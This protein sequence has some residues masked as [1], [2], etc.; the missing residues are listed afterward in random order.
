MLK[1]SRQPRPMNVNV[2]LAEK[3]L[4]KYMG[5]KR[6]AGELKLAAFM[7]GKL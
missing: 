3:R 6:K 7:T 5:K 1:S 2:A 4:S